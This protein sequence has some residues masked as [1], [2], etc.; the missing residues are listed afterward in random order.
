MAAI[1]EPGEHYSDLESEGRW[2]ET[3][4]GCTFW[5]RPLF[6]MLLTYQQ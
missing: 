1:L 4:N 6:S 5:Y 3:M 2:N